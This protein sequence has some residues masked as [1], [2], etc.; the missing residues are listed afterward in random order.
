MGALVPFVGTATVVVVPPAAAIQV[1][2]LLP[3]L[4]GRP[5]LEVAAPTAAMQ[6]SAL[7]PV[8][9]TGTFLEVPAAAVSLAGLAPTVDTYGDGD[10]ATPGAA[11]LYGATQDWQAETWAA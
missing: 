4:I 9:L 6:L 11:D 1:T 10:G 3:E 8:V 7:P 5:R 2:A